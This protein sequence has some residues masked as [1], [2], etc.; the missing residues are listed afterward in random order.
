MSVFYE[1]INDLVNEVFSGLAPL[2]KMQD[3]NVFNE[4]VT[5]RPTNPPTD[6][7]HN[8]NHNHIIPDFHH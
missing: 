2:D 5:D 8:H 6:H 4:C 7:N 1:R 3:S